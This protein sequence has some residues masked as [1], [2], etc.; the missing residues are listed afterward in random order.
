M[1]VDDG[2]HRANEQKGGTG[3]CVASRSNNAASP[4]QHQQ[5]QQPNIVDE[6]GGMAPLAKLLRASAAAQNLAVQGS[7]SNFF[8]TEQGL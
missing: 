3:R 1:D 4:N 5:Q 6:N 7:P 2:R 8:D